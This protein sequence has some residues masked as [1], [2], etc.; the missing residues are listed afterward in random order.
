MHKRLPAS[1]HTPTPFYLCTNAPAQ[2]AACHQ[3]GWLGWHLAPS[4]PPAAHTCSLRGLAIAGLPLAATRTA[5]TLVMKDNMGSTAI[6]V[7]PM[8]YDSQAAFSCRSK[9]LLES[10]CAV[11]TRGPLLPNICTTALLEDRVNKDTSPASWSQAHNQRLLL[12]VTAE[13]GR[14]LTHRVHTYADPSPAGLLM[15]NCITTR[16]THMR[17]N[18]LYQPG[19][20]Q[21]P[22]VKATYALQPTYIH[23]AYQ[24][25]H[26]N[27][28]QGTDLSAHSCAAARCSNTHPPTHLPGFA[29]CDLSCGRSQGQHP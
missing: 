19:A 1:P 5:V 13:T 11:T 15:A 12:T 7:N 4:L 26:T 22:P 14:L 9:S 28:K 18:H 2:P 10:Y 8:M 29:S 23:L 20:L 27:I 21:Q 24:H 16:C 25:T 6:L 17:S 3:A